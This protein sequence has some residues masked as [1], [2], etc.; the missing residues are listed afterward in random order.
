VGQEG[1]PRVMPHALKNVGKC[2]G[3]NPHTPKGVSTLGIGVTM[4]SRIFRER[5]QGS[6][7]NELKFRVVMGK[8]LKCR[9]LKWA[10]M[11]HLDI[12]NTGYGQKKL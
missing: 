5:L 6:K 8:L 4:D 3:M 9:C 10:R 12:S 2:E 7:L 11:T 1:S